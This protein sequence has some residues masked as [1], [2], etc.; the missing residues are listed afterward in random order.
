MEPLQHRMRKVESLRE[1]EPP[2]PTW[3]E[4]FC[5]H[6]TAFLIDKIKSILRPLIRKRQEWLKRPR[7][8]RLR[9]LVRGIASV[10]LACLAFAG[11]LYT[12]RP[13]VNI[14]ARPSF[15]RDNP[16]E[17]MFLITNVGLT[18][19]SNLI[20]ACHVE[21]TIMADRPGNSVKVVMQKS[22]DAPGNSLDPQAV[23]HPQ[24]TIARTC[25]IKAIV[26][27]GEDSTPIGEVTGAAIVLRI[28]YAHPYYLNF[29][30]PKM[31]AFL[32]RRDAN[33]E[34]QWIPVA[35]ISDPWTS[36]PR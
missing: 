8:E 16:Y 23:L 3:I 10:L 9:F 4:R 31:S 29:G 7:Q 30:K 24:D 14:A 19:I 15:N 5:S 1:T 18:D 20:F 2:V 35:L 36:G 25:A 28:D 34:I 26:L 33:G 13:Q 6:A 11:F 12:V 32:S 17:P 22:A 27:H 21:Y